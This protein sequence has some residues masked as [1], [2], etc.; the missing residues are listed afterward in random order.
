M[1]WSGSN[2]QH[3][4]SKS[5]I[6][7]PNTVHTH[8]I[9]SE[10]TVDLFQ[11]VW[12]AIDSTKQGNIEKITLSVG[13]KKLDS[14]SSFIDFSIDSTTWRAIESCSVDSSKS[15]T[16]AQRDA[17]MR[18]MPY[19]GHY[20]ITQNSTELCFWYNHTWKPPNLHVNIR[21]LHDKLCILADVIMLSNWLFAVQQ[22]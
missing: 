19:Q 5:A 10:I 7:P 4:L 9:L 6:W 22:T 2:M 8:T 12:N 3:C 14:T 21:A 15:K 13:V 20:F 18:E 11:R 17:E 1:R 16:G